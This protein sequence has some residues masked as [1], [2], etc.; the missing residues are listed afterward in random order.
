MNKKKR[1]IIF[2]FIVV[3]ILVVGAL[4]VFSKNG[5]KKG[6]GAKLDLNNKLL[7]ILRTGDTITLN[8]QDLNNLLAAIFTK[9]ITKEDLRIKT[10]EGFLEGNYMGVKIP[11]S[12]KGLNF[13]IS[14]KG[15][16]KSI[17]GEI[18][19]TPQYFKLGRF[20]VSKKFV[21]DNLKK[22]SGEKVTISNHD[23]KLNRV[24][25]PVAI[26]NI[27]VDDGILTISVDK[28]I[29]FMDLSK[30]EIKEKIKEN[31]ASPKKGTNISKNSK[32]E[33]KTVSNGYVDYT[34]GK[35]LLLSKMSKQLTDSILNIQSSG[36]Q[37]ITG[38]MLA[39]INKITATKDYNYEKDIQ[40]IKILWNK[41]TDEE[42]EETKKIIYSNLDGDT[43][44]EFATM[45]K[46]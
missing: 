44:I 41:L 28:Q 3:L 10:P 22:F 42:K 37:E 23:I 39:T 14:T 43:K 16:I 4:L 27:V 34:K 1:G 11:I 26:K 30:E 7:E 29:P 12:I 8:S 24:I 21:F 40:E 13:V 38:L 46:I 5:Y 17:N 2:T 36:G 15:D 19:Y 6:E 31:E 32:E 20:R 35:P 9:E 33:M 18:I 25:I 45:F